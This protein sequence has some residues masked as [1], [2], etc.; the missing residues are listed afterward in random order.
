[1]A[2]RIVVH[3]SLH[4]TGTFF[5]WKKKWSIFLRCCLK[6]REDF[7]SAKRINLDWQV[8]YRTRDT[9]VDDNV[10]PAFLFLTGCQAAL[11]VVTRN[12]DETWKL[13]RNI[14]VATRCRGIATQIRL[15]S[16]RYY[17][18]SYSQ[19]HENS[20]CHEKQQ[21]VL[22]TSADARNSRSHRSAASFHDCT[23]VTLYFFTTRRTLLA[24]KIQTL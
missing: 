12:H 4:R 3:K 14:L 21:H 16:H 10:H 1:M 22:N 23:M 18:Y 17:E 11:L 15:S 8:V 7:S 9:Y 6:Q 5:R 20:A 13:E 19:K 24:S 2:D